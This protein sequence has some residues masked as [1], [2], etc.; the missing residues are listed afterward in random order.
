MRLRV[1]NASLEVSDLAMKGII[2]SCSTAVS[3]IIESSIKLSKYRDLRIGELVKA[4]MLSLI[5]LT[6]LGCLPCD[7]FSLYSL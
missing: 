5:H 2:S 6:R 1:L 4:F 7:L 3:F